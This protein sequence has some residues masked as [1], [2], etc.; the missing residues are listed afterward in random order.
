M[1][2]KP[3]NKVC[4]TADDKDP[5]YK[6][7]KMLVVE[8]DKVSRLLIEIITSDIVKEFLIANNGIE[9]VEAC[10]NNPDI[11]LVLMDISMPLM[12]GYEATSKIREFNKEVVII[13]QTAFGYTSDREMAIAAGCNDYISKPINQAV[14]R[15]ML[16]KY[17]H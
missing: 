5:V 8:D 12:D 9:A 1:E 10:R 15:K 7:I 16:N 2:A 6:K 11:N 14:F 13:A 4:A 3:Y 17:I